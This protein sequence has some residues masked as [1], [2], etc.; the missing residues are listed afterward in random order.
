MENVVYASERADVVHGRWID[1]NPDEFLDTRMKC[2]V[3]SAIEN[4]LVM[5][6]YCPV[7][8]AKMDGERRDEHGEAGE[9]LEGAASAPE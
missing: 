8:G 3:C 4:P 9:L 1:E 2:S 7:Y 5:W 6:R